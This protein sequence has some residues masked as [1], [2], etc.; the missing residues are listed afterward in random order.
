MTMGP[1]ELAWLLQVHKPYMRA[2]EDRIP[3]KE[4]R[5]YIRDYES[6]EKAF[7]QKSFLEKLVDP[8]FWWDQVLDGRPP[9]RYVAYKL[10]L[11][12]KSS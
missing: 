6:R 9:E 2:I 3:S 8:F 7:K 1:R 5:R 4:L 12:E 10:L 11:Q